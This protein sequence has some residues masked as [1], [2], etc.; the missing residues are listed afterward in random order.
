[1]HVHVYFQLYLRG[2]KSGIGILIVFFNLCL[3]NSTVSSQG[4]DGQTHPERK[5][6]L[7]DALTIA[8]ERNPQFQAMRDQ[9]DAALGSLKQSKLYP[10]PVLELLAEEMPTHEV[11]LSQGQNLVAIKQPII[12][13]GKRGVGI[14]LNEKS[15]E[16]NE[17]ERDAVLLNVLADTKKAFYKVVADQESFAIAQKVE[18]IAK[19]IYQSEKVRFKGGEIPITNVLRAEV[20]LSKAKNSVSNAEGNLQNSLKELQTVM[21]N[22][23]ESIAGV[24]GKLLINSGEI[25]LDELELKMANNQPSLKASKKNI[26]M[27]N[28][29]VVFDERQAIPDMN[30]SA[31]YK[32]LSQENL[33]TIQFGI[34]VPAPLFNR[35]QG[36]IQKSRALSRKAKNDYQT[37]YNDLL[38]QLRKDVTSYNI[39]Q[40][41]ILEYRDKILPGADNSLK[42]IEKGYKEGEFGYLDLLDAQRTWAETGISYIESLK[43]LNLLISDIERL[44]V[45]KIGG[46]DGK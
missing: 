20:E 14:K 16:K 24:T 38:F 37:V 32:R 36:N 35:N 17:F 8:L 6:S 25:S 39:E 43:N 18:K 23:E 22:P 15:K 21:G 46:S 31:G 7:E 41:R 40:K 27:A 19:K 10:N 29:Q 30:V 12:M 13:G 11:G 42:L 33:D 3:F 44:A 26:E 34:E 9:V 45:V 28:T 5:I 1:M 4:I 2:Y